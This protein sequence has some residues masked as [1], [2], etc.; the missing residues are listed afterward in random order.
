M[1]KRPGYIVVML[2]LLFSSIGT[3]V[4][5]KRNT[6]TI[7]DDRL[8]LRI[9]LKSPRKE[10]DS[11]LEVAGIGASFA[12]N[13]L[14]GDFTA[15]S[16]DGWNISE[17]Q[18][19]I[20]QFNRPLTDLNNNPQSS[21]YLITTRIEQTAGRPGY[22]ENI[23]YGVNK[24]AKIT[25]Y[26]LQSG[27]TRF[28]LPGH[29][30]AQ[31]VFLSGNFND[32][33]T[34]KG[35]MKKTDGGW[36][37]DIMLGPG[38]YE[39][40]YIID[41]NWRTDPNNLLQMDDGAGN[42]NSVYYKY[43]HT[44]KLAG[45]ASARRITVAGD[46]D[47]WDGNELLMEKKGNNWILQMYLI[48]GKHLYRFLIDGKW[49]TD[50]ANP[51]KENDES[52]TLSSVLNLGKTVKFE[53]SGHL[54]AKKIML[55]GNFNH[56]KPNELYMKRT[57]NG[58]ILPLTLA[59]GNYNYKFIADSNWMTDPVNPYYAVEDG[60]TNSFVPV[61]PN[62]TFK[63]KGYNDARN[64]KLI[65]NFSKWEKGEYTLAHIKDEWTIALYLKPGKYIY[66][67]VVDGRRIKD[68]AN[69]LWEPGEDDTSNSVLWIE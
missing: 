31:R 61:K 51:A 8:V 30:N 52:G 12:Q 57:A 9:D 41:G 60:V 1:M 64:V 3:A 42:I 14:R 33:S 22:P 55:A 37:L 54:N 4:A 39:Y 62:Y 7:A 56:W 46:F 5:Q 49:V 27:L 18:A 34:L 53:L 28:I 19:D 63:L 20:I 11:I 23:L 45:Y 40:K 24:F 48:D 17:R 2:I 6:L 69:K 43:N 21:P 38:A 44:F 26:E 50:P 59:A 35:L 67:F 66:E 47:K 10:L 68:P 13:I 15:M 25:I 32:W 36:M 16:N 29:G 58:W 65:G